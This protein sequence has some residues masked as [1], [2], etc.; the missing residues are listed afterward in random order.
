MGA[1]LLPKLRFGPPIEVIGK[2]PKCCQVA[3][4]SEVAE[5]EP[6]LMR[7]ADN[8]ISSVESSEMAES[9]LRLVQMFEDL[10]AKNKTRACLDVINASPLERNAR[11][12][13]FA[14]SS[15]MRSI[16]KSA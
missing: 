2:I 3:T 4:T 14:L 5:S 10:E 16:S 1:E 6:G 11:E 15:A 9:R 8:E 7:Y 13:F 12:P